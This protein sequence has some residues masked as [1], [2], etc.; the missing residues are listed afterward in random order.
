MTKKEQD[1]TD[2]DSE[3]LP[4]AHTDCIC[5]SEYKLTHCYG[6]TQTKH[7]ETNDHYTV[8][9]SSSF[10]SANLFK[11]CSAFVKRELYLFDGLVLLLQHLDL[12]LCE[13]VGVVDGTH[14]E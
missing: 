3:D 4:H 6:N 10:S 11:L 13:R 8:T 1:V 14:S 12:F 7:S 5:S 9:N 2:I